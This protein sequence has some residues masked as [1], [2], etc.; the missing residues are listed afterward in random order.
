MDLRAGMLEHAGGVHHA[1]GSFKFGPGPMTTI[2]EFGAT[3]NS[4]C[5]KFYCMP[6]EVP[7]GVTNLVGENPNSLC[8]VP[9]VPVLIT[10]GTNPKA[11]REPHDFAF[12]MALWLS[13]NGNFFL[14]GS[15][16]LERIL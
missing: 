11:E 13:F 10:N 7:D 1:G 3:S 4:R 12:G 9:R 8:V 5:I 6:F 2:P 15:N 16:E 14:Y